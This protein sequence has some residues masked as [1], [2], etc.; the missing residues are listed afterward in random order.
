[1]RT[2][3]TGQPSRFRIVAPILALLGACGGPAGDPEASVRAWVERGEAAAESKDR[4]ALVGMISPAYVDARGNGR[5]EIDGLLRFYFLRQ[6][7]VS[8]L[9]RIVR[10]EIVGDSAAELELQVGMAGGNDNLLGFSA[11]AYRFDL[12]LERESG[13]WYLIAARWAELGDEVH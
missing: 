6:Q 12:E 13:D 10:I 1:M 2:L 4:R 5:D 3:A 11:R 8:L 7:T 9:V